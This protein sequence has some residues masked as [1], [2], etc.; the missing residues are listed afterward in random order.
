MVLMGCSLLEVEQEILFIGK[1]GVADGQAHEEAVELGFG[2]GEGAFVFDGVLSGHDHEGAGQG[3]GDA[4]DGDLLLLHGFEEGGLGAGGGAV[5]LVGQKDIDKDG[6]GAELELAVLL[7][8]DGYAGDVVGEQVGG[9]LQ[10]LELP[11]QADG[12][13]AGEHGLADAGNILDQ[14]VT[15]TEQGHHQEFDGVPFPHD[16]A[17]D[18]FSDLCGESLDL[19]HGS[20]RLMIPWFTTRLE[21]Q[22]DCERRKG[23]RTGN[24]E[25]EKMRGQPGGPQQ[26]SKR[27]WPVARPGRRKSGDL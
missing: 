27:V 5:D 3:M 10:A 22:K 14:D 8:V 2:E 7:V 6:A 16:D 19:V 20:S 13:G 1:N 11:A 21:L 9:A 15:F 26:D 23:K 4:V 25:Q 17:F 12:E 24:V 18:V